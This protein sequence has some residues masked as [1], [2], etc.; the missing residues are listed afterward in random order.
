MATSIAAIGADRSSA[1]PSLQLVTAAQF[2]S[3]YALSPHSDDRSITSSPTV[4]RLAPV[5]RHDSSASTTVTSS[6][7]RHR[8]VDSRRRQREAELLRR[9][10]ALAGGWG[11]GSGEDEDND[12][13]VVVDEGGK[14]R[15]RRVQKLD[16]LEQALGKMEAMQRMMEASSAA[17]AAS[18]A[19]PQLPSAD[20]VGEW[21]KQEPIITT[22]FTTTSTTSVVASSSPMT[23]TVL[24][25]G[26][27]R[28]PSMPLSLPGHPQSPGSSQLSFI[29]LQPVCA[30]RPSPSPAVFDLPLDQH[31]HRCMAEWYEEAYRHSPSA[32]VAQKVALHWQQAAMTPASMHDDGA[33]V[34]ATVPA[35]TPGSSGTLDSHAPFLSLPSSAEQPQTSTVDTLAV[36]PSASP[37][38]LLYCRHRAIYW[39]RVAA[40]SV[41]EQRNAMPRDVVR[42]LR[43]AADFIDSLPDHESSTW[44]RELLQVL[45]IYCS[46]YSCF[47]GIT[48]TIAEWSRLCKLCAEVQQSAG[49]ERPDDDPVIR[50]HF[51][52]L[53]GYHLALSASVRTPV[54]L[55]ETA[56]TSVKLTAIAHASG[57][58]LMI[59]HALY[60]E[61]IEH[62]HHGRYEQTIR[63]S[64][65][66]W[67]LCVP[68]YRPDHPFTV[69][70]LAPIDPGL[71]ALLCAA[72]SL[73]LLG[74]LSDA[75][76]Y[77]DR[78]IL[79]SS[80]NEEPI[81]YQWALGMRC[82]ILTQIG[83]LD[84]AGSVERFAAYFECTRSS[85][86]GPT[87]TLYET[88]YDLHRAAL[89]GGTD[90]AAVRE[91][92]ERW[93]HQYQEGDSFITAF[94]SPL[95]ELL[96]RAGMWSQGLQLADQWRYLSQRGQL[97][98]YYPDCHRYRAMFLLQKARHMR[99]NQQQHQVQQHQYHQQQQQHRR[100]D[101]EHAQQQPTP[102][103]TPAAHEYDFT[104][105]P[106]LVRDVSI[107]ETWPSPHSPIQLDMA[108]EPNHHVTAQPAVLVPAAATAA[109][110]LPEVELSLELYEEA[111]DELKE[112]I[113]TAAATQARLLEMQALME[114]IPLLQQLTQLDSESQ[115]PATVSDP[116]DASFQ[117]RLRQNMRDAELRVYQ[118]RLRQLLSDCLKGNETYSVMQRAQETLATYFLA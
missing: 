56:A 118:H 76:D 59:A 92:A 86:Q 84:T 73:C 88:C 110:V 97:A 89:L 113:R 2:N 68:Y 105:S 53:R 28:L 15:R 29:S 101:V 14:A 85:E 26:L 115:V 32:Y 71:G 62:I 57:D 22:S 69:N 19:Q 9:L 96:H 102:Q 99:S 35:T 41:V 81:T 39:L 23:V 103:A 44:R 116:S 65:R 72:N 80:L 111:V 25:P 30:P 104:L 1:P 98:F 106:W 114:V 10:H 90:S 8:E 112:A 16:I 61:A 18:H 34:S 13:V 21:A 38:A 108:D 83:E 117:R 77:A 43:C 109:A 91:S 78:C 93:W 3:A 55:D 5:D 4:T 67:Q 42:W 74:R 51:Y 64:L 46:A 36:S 49:A 50:A 47:V 94:G 63:T 52:A 54:D 27:S 70:P 48:R 31:M 24:P 66:A 37:A 82:F 45:I 58:Y 60:V 7:R 40:L 11:T 75:A 33:A 100:P 79:Q 107:T 6:K 12:V 95:C 20:M 17:A 87:S